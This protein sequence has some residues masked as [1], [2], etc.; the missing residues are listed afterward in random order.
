M[1]VRAVGQRLQDD[2]IGL[3]RAEQV[4]GLVHL[5]RPGQSSRD[6]ASVGPAAA[7]APRR[8]RAISASSSNAT[9]KRPS[10]THLDTTGTGSILATVTRL[11]DCRWT[12]AD[13]L[14]AQAFGIRTGTSAVRTSALRHAA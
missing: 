4:A 9:A 13:R 8:R 12:I 7:S 2:W 1:H 14:A 10:K 11:H 5:E 6:P 3:D